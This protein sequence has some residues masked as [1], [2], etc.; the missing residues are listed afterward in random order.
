MTMRNW[1]SGAS[2]CSPSRAALLTGRLSVRTG[3]YPETFAPDA[4]FGLPPNETTVAT[5]LQAKGW[6]TMAIGKWHLGHLPPFLPTSHGFDHYLGVP[7]AAGSGST[8]EPPNRCADD[9]NGTR[10]MPLFR[11][12]AIAQAPAN[13]SSLSSQYAEAARSFVASAAPGPTP[14]LLYMAFSHMHQICAPGSP[15]GDRQWGSPSFRVLAEQTTAGGRVAAS[16]AEVDW[17]TGEVLDALRTAGVEEDTL[18][19]WVSDDGPWTVSAAAPFASSFEAQSSGCTVGAAQLRLGRAVLQ[20]L[21]ARQH[22]QLLHR[23]P[24]RLCAHP[25]PRAA[26]ALHLL[27]LHAEA[28]L[29]DRRHPVR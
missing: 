6:R 21:G 10:W 4:V 22:R 17:L 15:P 8:I 11:D 12:E 13:L 16:L 3:I 20:P 25:E 23:L 27:R 1:I 24:R 19:F 26:A 28:S 7:F 18:V 29:P 9:P 5:H 2:L 14:F